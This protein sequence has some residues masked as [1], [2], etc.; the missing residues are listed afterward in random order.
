[1]NQVLR[2]FHTHLWRYRV[3]IE[4]RDRDTMPYCFSIDP[5]GSFSCQRNR[6]PDTT[7]HFSIP[8]VPPG[9]LGLGVELTTSCVPA[10]CQ[11]HSSC[12][13]RLGMSRKNCS[14]KCFLHVQQFFSGNNW[15]LALSHAH[16]HSCLRA[17]QQHH[18]HDNTSPYT[19]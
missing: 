1:M 4:T 8:T 11:T 19:S 17:C 3:E 13:A 14:C 6:Q 12:G 7:H 2:P 9:G 18:E 15:S 10:E 5:K 16:A